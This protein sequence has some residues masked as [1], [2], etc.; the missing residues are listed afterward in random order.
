MST[1]L[2]M[3]SLNDN[4]FTIIVEDTDLRRC[5]VSNSPKAAFWK[6]ASDAL[7]PDAYFSWMILAHSPGLLVANANLLIAYLTLKRW[8]WI[9]SVSL[10]AQTLSSSPGMPIGKPFS[11]NEWWKVLPTSDISRDNTCCPTI[12]S[13]F[14]PRTKLHSSIDL[15]KSNQSSQMSAIF[16]SHCCKLRS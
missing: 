5:E 13:N 14:I 1:T 3:A 10:E 12:A 6:S 7:M 15:P 9:L 11:T 2:I 4:L 8:L 16:N